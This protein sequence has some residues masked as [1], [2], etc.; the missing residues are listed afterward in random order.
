MRVQQ[1]FM[2][3]PPEQAAS[4]ERFP[5]ELAPHLLGGALNPTVAEQLQGRAHE[6]HARRG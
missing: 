5:T 1:V 4:L 6:G 2:G 3:M